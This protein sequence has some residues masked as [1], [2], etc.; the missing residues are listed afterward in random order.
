MS[1]CKAVFLMCLMALGS[2]LLTLPTAVNF[3]EIATVHKSVTPFFILAAAF[4]AGA[5]F[6]VRLSILGTLLGFLPFCGD[7]NGMTIPHFVLTAFFVFLLV[8]I[9][10]VERVC[11]NMAIAHNLRQLEGVD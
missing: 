10:L 9:L 4:V 7:F 1:D 2:L 3:N 5:L 6:I 11:A 8:S